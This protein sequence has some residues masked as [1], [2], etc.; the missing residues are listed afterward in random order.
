MWKF[1]IYAGI[2]YLIMLLLNKIFAKG[3]VKKYGRDIEFDNDENNN[4][5]DNGNSRKSDE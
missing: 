5:N 2:F 4:N 1:V 3:K